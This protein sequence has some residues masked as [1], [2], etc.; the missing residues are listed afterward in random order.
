LADREA[1]DLTGDKPIRVKIRLDFRGTAKPGKFFFGGKS[2]EKIAEEAREQNVAVFRNI[3][4]QGIKILDIDVGT[5]V[6]TVFDDVNN[7]DV[8]YAPIILDVASE[9]LEDLMK[10]IAREEFRRIEVLNPAVIDLSRFD[11]E[12][13]LFRVA[14]EIKVYRNHVERKYNLK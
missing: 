7:N 10:L 8:A 6:Y 13:L 4:V 9:S 12:R 14:E 5:E 11:M 3:P 2:V 1:H